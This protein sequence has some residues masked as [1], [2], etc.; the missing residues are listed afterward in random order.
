MSDT[1]RTDEAKWET[2]PA[3]IVVSIYFAQT[4]ERENV[5]LREQSKAQLEELYRISEALGTNEGHSSV[6][7]IET[8]REQLKD[9]SAAFDKQQEMLDRNAEQLA[10]KQARIDAL[11]FEYCPI[12]MSLEQ[13]MEWKK[14]QRPV[15]EG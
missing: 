1:P 4:L 11:M 6:T 5:A 15:Q 2:A 10:N 13:I 3:A 8:L 14:H 9:C 7:H 12:E